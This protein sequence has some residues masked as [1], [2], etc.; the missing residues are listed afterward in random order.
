MRRLLVA[1][2]VD[3]EQWKALTLV[4]LKLDL[5]TSQLG[6]EQGE[7]RMK[8]I[9][10]LLG[11][12][13]VYTLFGAGL[14]FVLWMSPD[15]FFAGT[16]AAS[17]TLFMVGAAVLLDH[18]SA[19][20][21][22]DD[23]AIL[24]FRPITSR[25]YFAVRLTNVLAFTTFITTVVAWLPATALFMRYGPMVGVAG[26]LEFFA[27]S[28]T[29]TLA[30]LLGYA[31]LMRVVGPDSLKRGLSYLQL[32]MSFAVY[33]GYAVI[34]RLVTTSQAAVALPK[35]PWLLLYPPTW[36]GS[37]LELAAGRTGPFE[38]GATALSVV[39]FAAMVTGLGGRLSLQYSERLGDIMASTR[40]KASTGRRPGAGRWFATGE[41]RAVALLVRSQF[42][43]DQRFRMGV[44]SVVPMTLV[45]M[46]L[47]MSD[48]A[49]QDPFV[50]PDHGGMFVTM[51]ILMFPSMVKLSLAHSDAFRAS[52]IFFACPVDRVQVIRSAKNVLVAWF[53]VPYLAIVTA[54]YVYF[55]P[56]VTHVVVHLAL[57]GLVSHLCL[58]I[59]VLMDPDLPFSKPP[60]KGRNSMGLILYMI[61]IGGLST[62]LGSLSWWLY[63][64]VGS[65]L[66][67]FGTVV[68]ASIGVE[69]MTRRRVANDARALEFEG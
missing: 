56:N 63:A 59:L 7:R 44:L 55:V 57:V 50:R 18:N 65:T 22:P 33:G 39:A 51:A 3:P 1:A 35:T 19:L 16:L 12:L 8:G 4:A 67:T 42:R 53:L 60:R 29:T 36:F 24:G 69:A 68:G 43:D 6:F 38:I 41:A 31:T 13:V 23:Y 15:L 17:Y 21:S 9:P 30:I 5:R 62:A 66:V 25:T 52:W 49:L 10:A 37:Y 48:G 45:Y 28:T 40:S 54:V 46:F 32:A 14:A 11:Q 64:S 47:G 58:E 27:C 61:G 34:P 26:L 20:A 2:G